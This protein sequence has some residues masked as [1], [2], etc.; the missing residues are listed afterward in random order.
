M[1]YLVVGQGKSGT[2]ALFSAIAHG[3]PGTATSFEP[4]C[5]SEHDLAPE[6]LVVKKLVE[7]WKPSENSVLPLFSH[8]LFMIRDPRDSL[9]SR[10]LYSI[11]DRRFIGDDAKLATFLKALRSKENDPGSM[12][13]V[14]LFDVVGSLDDTATVDDVVDLNRRTIEFWSEHSD[15]FFLVRYE[16]FVQGR[17]DGLGSYLGFP[18][19]HKIEVSPDLRRVERRKSFGD[20]R[21]WFT[22]A[23]CSYFAER[24][25]PIFETFGYDSDASLAENPIIDPSFSSQY[26]LRIVAEKRQTLALRPYQ[27]SH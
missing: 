14:E 9:V 18:I 17:T 25:Q 19:D 12:S 5:L 6:P 24:F 21:N 11:W 10:L 16:D 15:R 3:R 4:R 8:R 13:V 20:F 26:V 2:T 7:S 1:R 22:E 27:D 23:D